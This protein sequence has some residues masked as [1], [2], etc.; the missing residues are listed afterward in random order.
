MLVFQGWQVTMG[1]G[2]ASGPAHRK[3][4]GYRL[5]DHMLMVTADN[6]EECVSG[7]RLRQRRCLGIYE[8]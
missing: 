1:R 2:F 4:L 8:R 3:D 7:T 5:T 6:M